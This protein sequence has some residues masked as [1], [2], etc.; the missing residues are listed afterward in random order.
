MQ[1]PWLTDARG[2]IS[3]WSD[4][5]ATRLRQP[6]S[7]GSGRYSFHSANSH[8]CRPARWL[9]D[10]LDVGVV[11]IATDEVVLPGFTSEEALVDWRAEGGPFVT[12]PDT[13]GV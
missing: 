11:T 8:R 10:D 4:S 2:S 5:D 7:F 1:L 6:G 13:A 3:A 9:E 12:R